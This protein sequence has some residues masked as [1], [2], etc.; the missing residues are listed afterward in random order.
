MVIVWTLT[1][2]CFWARQA[3]SASSSRKSALAAE[4]LAPGGGDPHSAQM[5]FPSNESLAGVGDNK[6]TRGN[7][8]PRAQA[9]AIRDSIV[10]A[11]V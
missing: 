10:N 9:I 6:K 5:A 7:G 4:Y 1:S 11:T 3:T 8:F 2:S